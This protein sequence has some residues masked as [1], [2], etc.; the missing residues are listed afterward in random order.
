MD[1]S[2]IAGRAYLN[3]RGLHHSEG[4]GARAASN[5]LLAFITG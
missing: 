4:D 1:W 5:H 3:S 2:D